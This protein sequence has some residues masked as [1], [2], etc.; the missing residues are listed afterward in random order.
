M[1]WK[2]AVHKLS[3][4]ISSDS[5]DDQRICQPM[6]GRIRGTSAAEPN[7]QATESTI[8]DF[9]AVVGRATNSLGY[10]MYPPPVGRPRAWK[11]RFIMVIYKESKI[12]PTFLCVTMQSRDEFTV[13]LP[14]NG[15]RRSGRRFSGYRRWPDL[16]KTAAQAKYGP[17]FPAHQPEKP[18]PLLKAFNMAKGRVSQGRSFAVCGVS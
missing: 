10:G 11:N 2:N 13:A 3:S 8:C 5:K 14:I 16:K 18:G 9:A 15:L 1:S 12:T 6:R 4:R 7:P 17:L